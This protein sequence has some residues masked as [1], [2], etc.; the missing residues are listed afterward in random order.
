MNKNHLEFSDLITEVIDIRRHLHMYPELSGEE[1]E[2]SKFIKNT[3]DSM[4]I[5]SEYAANTGVIGLIFNDASYPTIAIRAE[6][7]GLPITEETNLSYKS[8]NLG[9]MHGCSHDGIIVFHYTNSMPLGMEI[10]KNISTATIGRIS[11]EIKGKSSHWGEREK[12]IDSI[13]VSAKVISAIDEINN[14][15]S[16]ELPFVI[17][18]GMIHGGVKNNIMANLVEKGLTVGRKIFGD[19]CIKGT[20][21]Y[22]AGDNASYYFERVEG[23]R[24]VFFAQK[25]EEENYPLHNPKFDFD[26]SI[27][28]YAIET[29]YKLISSF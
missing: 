19:S 23:L 3:L 7:D 16:S 11:I 15:Y 5:E 10:Q 20:R 13:S 12:G 9:L 2:T 6:I 24:I 26:E 28:S 1:Y 8:K 21:P 29:L 18:I 27:F 4:G 17:G 22:L 25:K 14:T